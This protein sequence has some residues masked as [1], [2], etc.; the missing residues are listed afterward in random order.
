MPRRVLIGFA[1]AGALCVPAAAPAVIPP[2]N[3]GYQ[4]LKGKRYQIKAD[5]ISCK[6]AREHSRRYVVAGRKPR[7]YRCRR[8]STRRNSVNFMCNNGRKVFFGIRR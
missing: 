3:C 8:P 1:L 4:T 5:Q 7:G 6:T 2:K